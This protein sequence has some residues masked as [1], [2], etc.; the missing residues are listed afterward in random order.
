MILIADSGSTKADW[1]LIQSNGKVIHAHTMGLNP[2]FHGPDK[3]AA[4]LSS[5]EFLEL[6][7]AGEVRAL[8][9]YGAG[10][11]DEHFC[12]IMRAGL[13]RVFTHATIEVE[14]DL[15]G[16]ARA[17]CGRKPG[18]SGILG[19]GSNSC[20]YDGDRVVDNIP[21][22]GHVLG[23]DGGGVHLG[24][25]ALRAWYYRELPQELEQDFNAIYPEG[26]DAVM[27]RIYGGEGQN[28]HIAKFAGFL[29]KH[30]DHPF[31]RQLIDSAFREF[32]VRQLKKY[33]GW[34]ETEVNL[35]GSIAELLSKEL[36]EVF[37]SE[38]LQTGRIIRKP[39]DSL[40]EFHK[41]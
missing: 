40:V 7:P 10:C 18:I 32:A 3:V 26:K 19:T 4:V 8:H 24:R 16:A 37:S 12:S 2:Y 27:H 14:H 21:A 29:V 35:V 20:R 17:T 15:L 11:P 9:F 6:V 1:A 38:G 36:R 31:A 30:K 23:D 33:E 41:N 28:V 22:L 5:P 34:K 25:L 39:I 13:E